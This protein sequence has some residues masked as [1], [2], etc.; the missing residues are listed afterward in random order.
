MKKPQSPVNT[1]P[2]IVAFGNAVSRLRKPSL[3]PLYQVV[4]DVRQAVQDD[5]TDI[6]RRMDEH[7]LEGYEAA[8]RLCLPDDGP[9]TGTQASYFDQID[10]RGGKHHE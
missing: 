2:A 6:N 5:R 7:R 3:A 10:A 1:H 4:V 9:V 8:A